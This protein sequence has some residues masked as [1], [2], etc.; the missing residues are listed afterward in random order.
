VWRGF[1]GW[2]KWAQ[3]TTAVVLVIV[4]IAAIAGSGSNNDNNK[5]AASSNTTP[6]TTHATA[7]TAAPTTTQP[8]TT[9]APPPPGF[10]GTATFVVGTTAPAG[11]YVSTNNT[12]CYWERAKDASGSLDSIIENDN[13]VGQA[14]VQINNGEVFTTRDCGRWTLYSDP[15]QPLS[16]FGDGTWVV[17]GQVPP[18]RW[19][20]TGNTGCY[21]ERKQN[22]A[23]GVDSIAANDNVDGPTVV[24]IQGSDVAFK[25][26]DCGTWTKVG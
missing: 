2:P 5:S 14:L 23:G 4:I 26:K 16:T 25:S 24:D 13:A 8:P 20:S 7:S 21:W 1:R 11:T 10:S 18:G 6:S 15:G 9:T 3:I 22:L 12:T 19:Q 17:P